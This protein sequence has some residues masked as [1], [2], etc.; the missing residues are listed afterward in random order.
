M[1]R[2]AM[3]MGWGMKT[4]MRKCDERT[5]DHS[6]LVDSAPSSFCRVPR[7]RCPKFTDPVAFRRVM[8]KHCASVIKSSTLAIQ[9]TSPSLP[10]IRRALISLHIRPL[11]PAWAKWDNSHHLQ[12]PRQPPA[13]L[14]P[15]ALKQLQ[16]MLEFDTALLQDV[17]ILCRSVVVGCFCLLIASLV[18][19]KGLDVVDRRIRKKHLAA[20]IIGSED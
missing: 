12:A 15:L 16:N 9:G 2:M 1:T 7:P 17:V 6:N 14:C 19:L 10:S 20:E 4:K 13:L 11:P 3:S 18:V 5:T 8:R